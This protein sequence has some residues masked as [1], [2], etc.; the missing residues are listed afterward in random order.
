MMQLKIA[1]RVPS[2]IL[3]VGDWMV[4]TAEENRLR[5]LKAR[6]KMRGHAGGTLFL[7]KILWYAI[8]IN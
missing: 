4:L 3:S 2:E 7:V 5:P 1:L 6:I 8:E